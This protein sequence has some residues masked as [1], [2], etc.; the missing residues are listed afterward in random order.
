MRTWIAGLSI[1]RLLSD[2]R[3][4]SPPADIT[5]PRSSLSSSVRAWVGSGAARGINGSDSIGAGI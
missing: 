5:S 3:G 2:E 4:T 1:M